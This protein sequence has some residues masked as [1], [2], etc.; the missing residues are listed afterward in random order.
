MDNTANFDEFVEYYI[1]FRSITFAQRALRELESVG[2]SCLLS[3]TPQHI[4][5]QGC[6]YCVRLKQGWRQARELL[7]SR[8]VSYSKVYGM[9]KDGG[10]QE[11]RL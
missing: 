6:G 5:A 7:S 9:R 3:R 2:I 11:I 10:L 8:Q 4:A 1:T